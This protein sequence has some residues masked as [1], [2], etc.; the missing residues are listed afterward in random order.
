MLNVLILGAGGHAQVVADILMRA[1]NAGE[2]IELVGF[3]DDD[4]VS[5][6]RT[7]LG[8]PVLGS[9]R[10]LACIVH[11]ALIVGIGD[12]RTRK[13]LFDQMQQ[14]G[15]SSIIAEHPTAVVAPDVSI[16]P[17]TTI[18]AGVVINPGSVIGANVILNTGCTVDHHNRIGDHAHIAPG[19][20]LGGAVHIGEGTLVGIGATI[21]PNRRVGPWS[22]VGAGAVV[23]DDIPAS[24]VVV[25][26][27][28]RVVRCLEEGGRHNEQ[29]QS[30]IGCQV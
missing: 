23:V 3:L 6:G 19:V 14:Q 8:L 21:V 25:G 17:G 5:H 13:R 26:V 24:V 30:P 20:H 29:Q 28:A 18:C 1:H 12:N 9:I 7:M 11:N 22:T 10:D 15:E 16:G 27:P 4:S 2:Q